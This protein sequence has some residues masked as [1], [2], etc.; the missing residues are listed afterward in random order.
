MVS[1]KVTLG[2]LDLSTRIPSFPGLYS[3]L[4]F[5]AKRGLVNKPVL[6]TSETSFLNKFTP[7][8]TV[9]AGFD[10]AYYSGLNYLGYGNKLYGIRA[11]NNPL[12]GGV[13]IFDTTS[14]NNNM[15][16]VLG[17]TQIEID[18]WAFPNDECFILYG[19]DQGV[20]NIDT[21]ITIADNTTK[22][23]DSFVIKVYRI[24]SSE[25]VETW[26]CSR[27]LGKKDGFGNNIYLDDVLKR[28][29]YIRG[30]NNPT[31]LETLLPKDQVVL[32]SLEK[33]SDGGTVG[34]S[35]LQTAIDSIS[36]PEEF[37]VTLLM[38]GGYTDA[39]YHEKLII[40]AEARK[41]CVSLLSVPMDKEWSSTPVDDIVDWK[42]SSAG[43]IYNTTSRA[44]LYS[45]YPKIYDKFNER[46]IY[47]SPEGLA[48]SAIS[49][50]SILYQ[51][52]FAA[53]GWRRGVV[54]ILDVL[55]IYDEGERDL[56]DDHGI[57][58]I[59]FKPAKGF[60][61]WGNR[62]TLNRP[63][64][65]SF[66]NIRMLIITIAP[67]IAAA[68]EEFIFDQNDETTQ[69]IV[70]ALIEEYMELV[71]ARRGVYDYMVI[72]DGSNNDLNN[73]PEIL[74]VW[75]FVKPIGAVQWIKFLVIV[76]RVGFDFKL[77]QA[78]IAA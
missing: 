26:V 59:R 18:A 42:K 74:N 57:N 55:N 33:G 39:A 68:L 53:A 29:K 8:K 23:P 10:T 15:V 32:M 63:S 5:D 77:A 71:K 58:T 3:A 36:N 52:W 50:T 75:L 9:G 34:T 6:A 76:T 56:L 46:E 7:N 28:S 47:V 64:L 13:V 11:A 41:D 72:C 19:A 25:L 67:A 44:A 37:F 24:N 62:T 38:D 1:G 21:Y 73:E 78:T 54:N 65:L 61:L 17:L 51:P 60:A 40:I 27:I 12:Y 22:E 43:A 31:I 2:E 16:F 30:K 69:T 70:T 48:A 4:A 49:K 35:H 14:I 66:L 20:W 45:S